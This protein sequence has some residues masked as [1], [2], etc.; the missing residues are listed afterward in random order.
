MIVAVADNQFLQHFLSFVYITLGVANP[1][2][3]T[4]SQ[5]A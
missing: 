1:V 5:N 4:L 2:R 3:D